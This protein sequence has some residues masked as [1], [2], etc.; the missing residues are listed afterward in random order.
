M[1]TP[2]RVLTMIDSSELAVEPIRQTRRSPEARITFLQSKLAELKARAEREVVLV[3][4]KAHRPAVSKAPAPLRGV[5]STLSPASATK[6]H[7]DSLDAKLQVLIQSFSVDIIAL[8]KQAALEATTGAFSAP[9]T[10]AGSTA[11]DEPPFELVPPSQKR[12]PMKLRRAEWRRASTLGRPSAEKR[13]ESL[14]FE[15]YER[16]AIERALAECGGDIRA[17]G[18]RLKLSKSSIYRRIRSLGI[19][20]STDG[21]FAV[22]PD[23]PLVL[24]NEPHSLEAYEK[25]AI[26]RALSHGSGEVI[27]ASQLLRVGK[28]TLYRDRKSVV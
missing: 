17:A 14:S 24:T 26:L 11:E 28:S 15:H 9:M 7:T 25:A 19:R 20:P 5:L 23:D 16:M 4:V 2:N 21:T 6:R 18:A 22:S 12:M 1:T 10:I 8:L 27:A 13:G 3:P